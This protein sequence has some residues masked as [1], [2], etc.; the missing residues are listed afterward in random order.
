M[1][2]SNQ[3]KIDWGKTIFLNIPSIFLCLA[4]LTMV[5]IFS[6]SI[7]LFETQQLK[8]L[9]L[10]VM[11]PMVLKSINWLLPG[12]FEIYKKLK[13]EYQFVENL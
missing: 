9:Y 5:Y 1:V 12:N 8:V 6:D 11:F 7:K 4:M 3:E 13:P 2:D 10:A